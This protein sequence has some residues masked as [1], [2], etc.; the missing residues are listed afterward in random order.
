MKSKLNSCLF[1]NEKGRLF[2]I[3]CPF[4][5][6]WKNEINIQQNQLY[7]VDRIYQ[8]D[9]NIILYEINEVEVNHRDY[10]LLIW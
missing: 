7:V 2:R 8:I 3:T 9:D 6:R 10:E 5:V 4:K 1:V